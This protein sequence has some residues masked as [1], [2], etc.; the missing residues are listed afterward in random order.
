MANKADGD[1]TAVKLLIWLD[2]LRRCHLGC[3][4]YPQDECQKMVDALNDELTHI[5]AIEAQDREHD[6]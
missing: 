5:E 2:E 4:R 1:L 6:G 3:G